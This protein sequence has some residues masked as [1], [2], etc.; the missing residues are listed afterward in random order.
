[1]S[2]TTSTVVGDEGAGRREPREEE[3][4]HQT[5]EA[6]TSGI[7][8]IRALGGDAKDIVRSRV[9]LAPGAVW[10]EAARA[11]VEVL[12]ETAPANSMLFVH[13]LIGEGL[14]AEVELDAIVGGCRD[15]DLQS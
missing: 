6:L 11:H 13:E 2:G 10:R 12:G 7:R 8:A 9:F 14:L 4:Y 15:D 1:M 3:T 5:V